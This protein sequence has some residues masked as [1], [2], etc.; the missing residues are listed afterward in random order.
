MR[1]RLVWM[2]AGITAAPAAAH[3]QGTP[4]GPPIGADS[5][6]MFFIRYPA[7]SLELSEQGV[8][9]YRVAIDSNGTASECVVVGSSGFERLDR[10]TCA[11]AV[12]HA[13]FAPTLDERGHRTRSVYEGEVVWRTP[14]NFHLR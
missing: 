8:V 14:L 11:A 1:L 9:R 10:L 6:G 3:S 4:P 12:R 7:R 13:R 2:I 5:A